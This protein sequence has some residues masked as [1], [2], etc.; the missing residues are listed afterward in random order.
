VLPVVY[1]DTFYSSLLSGDDLAI[2]A[3][4]PNGEVLFLINRDRFNFFN[5]L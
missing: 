1:A 5:L 4:L 3:I 2:G